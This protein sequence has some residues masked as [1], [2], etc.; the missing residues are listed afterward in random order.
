[1]GYYYSPWLLYLYQRS[2]PGV[3]FCG[4]FTHYES[5]RFPLQS[6]EMKVIV[7]S[8]LAI[9]IITVAYVLQMSSIDYFG[10]WKEG[11][12]SG[13]SITGAD[14]SGDK[15]ASLHQGLPLSDFLE[16]STGVTSL[17]AGSCALAD[18]SR[19]LEEG[20]QYIQRT[21]NYR[22]EYPDNCSSTQTEFVGG[23]YKPLAIGATVPCDGQCS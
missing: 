4:V 16:V 7:V 17:D 12:I 15:L 2:Q 10:R 1:M 6:I 19:Q 3:T 14:T 23:F 21:N 13:G 22:R 18:S 8:T 20:G 9:L 11:F 5:K